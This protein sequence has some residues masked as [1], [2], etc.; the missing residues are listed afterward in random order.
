[1]FDYNSKVVADN[2]SEIWQQYT[3]KDYQQGVKWYEEAN[4]YS[5]ELAEKYNVTPAKAA[6]VLSALS[7]LKEWNDN[8]RIT[9][10]FF[11]LVKK[12]PAS[13][14]KKASHYLLQKRKA[15][16]IYSITNPFIDQIGDI[17]H[18]LKTKNFFY[19]I[20]NPSTTDHVCIDRHMIKVATGTERTKLTSKQY[21]FL[22]KEYLNFASQVGMN[23]AQ[24]QAVLWV[25]YKRIKKV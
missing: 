23:P 3:Y 18:G 16:K 15:W 6:G 25:T 24:M 21:L 22:K 14:W 4:Q 5:L 2:I 13:G 12:A 17:L 9:E 11:E 19:C 1:M 10:E 20:Q 7:P 8:K